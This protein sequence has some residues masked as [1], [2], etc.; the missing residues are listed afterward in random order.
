MNYSVVIAA[1]GS[2]SRMGLGYNKVYY[3]VNGRP[4]LAYT[5]DVI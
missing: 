5:I 1:A 3:P 4:L 2:G